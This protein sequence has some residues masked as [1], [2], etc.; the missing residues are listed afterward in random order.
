MAAAPD[1]I[2]GREAVL[3][4]PSREVAGRPARPV[5]GT[6][7][8]RGVEIPVGPVRP[9]IEL[10]RPGDEVVGL[11]VPVP[12]GQ[13]VAPVHAGRLEGRDP[14]PLTGRVG[15]VVPVRPVAAPVAARHDQETVARPDA[16]GAVAKVGAVLGTGPIVVVEVTPRPRPPEVARPPGQAT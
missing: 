1:A 13:V 6:V 4:D 5:A 15:V 3:A 10:G 16:V 12:V 2:H 7:A 8:R 9:T 14:V 11:L